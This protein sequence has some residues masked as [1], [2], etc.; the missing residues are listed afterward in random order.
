MSGPCPVCH[1]HWD[2]LA[3]HLWVVHRELVVL[4]LDSKSLLERTA[5]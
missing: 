4:V 2:Y 1:R 5:P 3:T